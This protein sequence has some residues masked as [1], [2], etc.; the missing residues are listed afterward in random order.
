MQLPYMKT[1]RWM[2]IPGDTL[3]AFGAVAVIAFV[4]G[5]GRRSSTAKG[6]RATPAPAV[7][8]P[9]AVPAGE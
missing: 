9:D 1:L 4:F 2:R 7:L 3:F 6:A 8:D 5:V